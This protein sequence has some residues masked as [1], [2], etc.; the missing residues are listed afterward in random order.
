MLRWI[1]D[2]VLKLANHRH[3]QTWLAG[4]SFAESSFFPIPVEIMLLPMLLA[5]RAWAF[6]LAL[7]TSLF[8]VL[9]GVAGYFVGALL[10]EQIGVMVLTLYG[11]QDQFAEYT[12][13]YRDWGWWIVAA[14]AVTPIPYKVVTIASG[15]AQLDLGLFIVVSLIG[16]GF[17]YFSLAA[18]FWWFGPPIRIFIERRLGVLTLVGM[19][20]L[21]VGF[22][23]TGSIS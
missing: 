21:I 17:R 14:G 7:I 20:L 5:R 9:G 15:V 1:Y 11:Y 16:R 8:S 10:Y 6:R 2:W 22:W 3:A 12:H 4:I 13:L 19:L 23:V 18:L